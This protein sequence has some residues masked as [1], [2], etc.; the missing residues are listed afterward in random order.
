MEPNE[1]NSAEKKAPIKI[2]PDVGAA[3]SEQLAER[4]SVSVSL[5]NSVSVSVSNNVSNSISVSNNIN[6]D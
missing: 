6:K 3:S 4:W 2:T 1:P 5:S